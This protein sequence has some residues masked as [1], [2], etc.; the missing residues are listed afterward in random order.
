[1]AAGSGTAHGAGPPSGRRLTLVTRDRV[2]VAACGLLGLL[3][4]VLVVAPWTS[5]GY[6]LLLDWVSGPNQTLTPGVFGLSGSAL[7]AVPF[8]IGTQVLRAL[9]GP[10]ATAWLLILAFFPV[11]AGGAAVAAGGRISRRMPAA[12]LFIC[13]PFVADRVRAGHVSFLLGVALLPWLANSALAARHRR[14]RIAVRPAFWFALAISVNPHA[15][16]LGGVLL[17]VVAV[18]PRPS[19]RDVLRTVQIVVAAGAVYTYSLVLWLTGT[20]TLEVTS[21]D[22]EAYATRPVAG[23]LMLTVASLRGFWRGGPVVGAELGPVL[24]LLLLLAL[25][26]LVLRGL[27]WL[28]AVDRDRGW[29]AVW[30]TVIGLLAGAGIAGPVGGLYRLAFAHLPLFEAMREQQKWLALA[31]LGYAMGF[32]AAVE[33]LHRV[34]VARAAGRV[35]RAVPALL[36]LL[37]L[38]VAPAIV[39]GLGG[40]I[41]TSRYPDSWAR[42]DAMMGAGS[43]LALFLPWH[44][45]QSFGFTA[46]RT[47]ATPANAYFQRQMIVSDAVELANLR[48]DS[49]SLRTA[50]LD[51]VLALGGADALGRLV[52]PL[53]VRYVVISGDV[54]SHDDYSWVAAQPGLEPLL[55]TA[56]LQLF[57]VVPEGTGRVVS[58]RT[59]TF[60]QAVAAG[61]ADRLGTTALL[62]PAGGTVSGGPSTAAGGIEKVSPTQWQV[63]PGP[64]GW[65]VVPEEFSSGWR[66]AGPGA[67][68]S[69]AARPTVAGTVALQVPAGPAEIHYG[70]WRFLRP[71][72]VA[73]LLA[74][75]VLVV[76]GVV[77]HR[78]ELLG[79]SW[80]HRSAAGAGT[81]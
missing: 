77:E 69:Q 45:Y 38:A 50:Y 79:R 2:E 61:A 29:F 56:D 10:A 75:L 76:G 31:V 48:T 78:N 63:S 81:R 25:I 64:A 46:G 65:V 24:G 17:V 71:A 19:W 62:D 11:A 40:D 12:L 4:G 20:R 22:L 68:G 18:A 53:G 47:V 58:G 6:L 49:T 26:V 16:W 67:A 28:T 60:E 55:V 37:P 57:R 3:F 72:I 9:F 39:W 59:A 44:G 51:R 36:G 8:R 7:D 43:E 21:A 34:A 54:A 42:A 5:G 14:S 13:N 15:A 80:R 32:G 66:L 35:G 74:L 33:W 70:P 41:R 52:A 73:S 23:G 27:V 1:M 30:L